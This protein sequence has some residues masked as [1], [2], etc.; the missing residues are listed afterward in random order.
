MK[1]K[2]ILPNWLDSHSDLVYFEKGSV[3]V[4]PKNTE[5]IGNLTPLTKMLLDRRCT[6]KLRKIRLKIFKRIFK[7]VLQWRPK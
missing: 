7:E 4:L 3:E 5:N 2:N 6:K 1:G